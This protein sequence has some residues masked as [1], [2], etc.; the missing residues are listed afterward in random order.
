MKCSSPRRCAANQLGRRI[1]AD[2]RRAGESLRP[3]QI[4]RRYSRSPAAGGRDLS[5][6]PIPTA[7]SSRSMF[8]RRSRCRACAR[9]SPATIATRP[10]GVLPIAH[11][12]YP[13]ARDSVRYSG[14]PIAAVA[15]RR[16][17]TP[18][19]K[20]SPHQVQGE[21]AAGL[22]H[23]QGRARRPT[24]S[25][26]HDNKPGNIERDVLFDLGSTDAGLRRRRPGARGHLSTAPRS[27]RTRWRCMRRSPITTG[28][29]TA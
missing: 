6:A 24:P 1:C 25:Q 5:A 23:R 28:C 12:E 18:P 16:R 14:E 21:R 13:L 10:F 8:P 29:A 7:T 27:A 26:L 2:G 20:P 15:A 17:C 3:R 9:S 4:H 19:T 11:S 22:F